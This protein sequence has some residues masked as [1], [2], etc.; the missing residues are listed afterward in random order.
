LPLVDREEEIDEPILGVALRARP[1]CRERIAALGGL[2][3]HILDRFFDRLGVVDVAGEDT[4][5][6]SQE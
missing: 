6:P 1:H 2:D 3:G 4:Q 5:P